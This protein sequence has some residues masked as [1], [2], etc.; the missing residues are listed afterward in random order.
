LKAHLRIRCKNYSHWNRI[1][2]KKVFLNPDSSEPKV[3]VFL[4]SYLPLK[5]EPCSKCKNVIAEPKELIRIVK[6]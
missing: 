6:S 3:K 2:V 1:E 5:S 4:P